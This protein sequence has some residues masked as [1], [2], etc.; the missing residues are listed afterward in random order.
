MMRKSLLIAGVWLLAAGTLLSCGGGSKAGPAKTTIAVI[1]KG[2]THEFW[3]AVHAGA[4]RAAGE[5]SVEIIWKGPLKE[6]DR[7]QQISV[8]QDFISRGVSGVVLAPLDDTALRAP[9]ADAVKAGIPVVIFDSGL[10]SEDYV[11]FVATDNQMGGKLAGEEMARRLNHKGKVVV[12]RYQEGSDSTAKR[13]Q[14]FL[15]AMA[16]YPDMQVISANQYAGPTTESAYTASEN[17]LAPLRVGD[18]S[19]TIDGIFCPNESS[20]FGMLRA[21]RDGGFAGQLRFIGFDSSPQ[22]VNALK[23]GQIDALTLQNPGKMGYLAVKTM[24]EHLAGKPV[25]KRIDTGVM[26]VTRDN[27]GTPEA[28]ELLTP[29]L[30]Q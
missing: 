25:E 22:L 14:G 11:S 9:V 16:E 12:L 8:V 28:Q 30:A 6:D 24:V 7:D 27:M 10:A 19:L 29:P 21:L 23:Q 15:D 18:G 26:V 3:K 1:P 5:L 4:Q 2:T 13:E 17:L 20:T